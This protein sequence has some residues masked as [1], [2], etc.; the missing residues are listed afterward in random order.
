MRVTRCRAAGGCSWRVGRYEVRMDGNGE[1]EMPAFDLGSAAV[2]G[3]AVEALPAEPLAPAS[4]PKT[5]FEAM[6]KGHY[7]M[8]EAM[9]AAK[10][11]MEEVESEEDE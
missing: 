1:E 8:K 5:K 4:K 9:M 2:S 10:R 7:N 3:A 11:L 6:R